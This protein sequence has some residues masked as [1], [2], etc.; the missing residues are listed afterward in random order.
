[1]KSSF[2]VLYLF[3]IFLATGKKQIQAGCSVE[4]FFQ[5]KAM[6]RGGGAGFT[7]LFG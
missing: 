3:R 6:S 1:M 4:D 5:H 2:S 7:S